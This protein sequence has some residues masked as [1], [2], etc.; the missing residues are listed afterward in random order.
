MKKNIKLIVGISLLVLLISIVYVANINRINI[1]EGAND[2]KVLFTPGDSAIVAINNIKIYKQ[3]YL[4]HLKKEVALTY[5]HFYLKYGL[6][7]SDGFWDTEIDNIKPIDY[8]KEQTNKKVIKSKVIHLL[9]K[10]YNVINNFDFEEFKIQWQEYN[11]SRKEAFE[12]DEVI[13]GSVYMDMTSYYNYLL[14]NLAIRVKNKITKQEFVPDEIA[15]RTFYEKIKGNTFAYFEDI[16]IEL[17]GYEYSSV[18][19]KTAL[20]KIELIKKK[21]DNGFSF[22]K[23]KNRFQEGIYMRKVFYDSIP[24]YGEDN[25]DHIIKEQAE[26]LKPHQ[27]AIIK[28]QEGAFVM[29]IKEKSTINYY[30]YNKVK[31]MTL[32]YYQEDAYTKF[33]DSVINSIKLHKN[34]FV[35]EKITSKDFK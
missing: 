13:Y 22:N 16:D 28:E 8:L 15:L 33:I 27:Y 4:I 1:E 12:K 5:N 34:K 19:Y 7:N 10:K 31:D 3:E 29:K 18:S 25:P 11:A 17:F 6:E 32:Q 2:N 26:K 20:E 30:S 35:Y 21:L 14:T 24:I 23:L 9:A